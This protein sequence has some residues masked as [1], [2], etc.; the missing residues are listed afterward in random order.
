VEFGLREQILGWILIRFLRNDSLT[1]V[2]KRAKK[3][4][5]RVLIPHRRSRKS[6]SNPL[7]SIILTRAKFLQTKYYY[8]RTVISMKP[9]YFQRRFKISSMGFR[10]QQSWNFD[11][12]RRTTLLDHNYVLGNLKLE[13]PGNACPQLQAR[14]RSTLPFPRSFR[15]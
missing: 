13:N 1:F 4:W 2:C 7:A 15:S 9:V 8:D 10:I 5:I 12:F 3:L 14:L 6:S 11:P